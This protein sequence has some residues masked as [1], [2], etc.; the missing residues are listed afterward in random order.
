[1]DERFEELRL[2]VE[3][4]KHLRSE[5][6]MENADARANGRPPLYSEEDNAALWRA[7]EIAA[8]RARRHGCDVRDLVTDD[9]GAS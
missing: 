8:S 5:A 2:D 1:M 4:I 9:I 6:A 3:R 7:L